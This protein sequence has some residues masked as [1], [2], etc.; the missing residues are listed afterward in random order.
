MSYE[1]LKA[2]RNNTKQ[3]LV[4]CLGGK[5]NRCSYANCLAALE[6]HHLDSNEKE[7]NISAWLSHPVKREIIVKEAKKCCLL[8]SNCHK[9]FHNNLWKMSDISLFIFDESFIPWFEKNKPVIC[10]HCQI[11][12]ERSFKNQ[13]FCSMSCASSHNQKTK[14][15][16]KETLEQLLW[17][18][19]STQIAKIYK[20]SDK[21]ICKWAKKYNLSKPP[22]GY[23]QVL[24]SAT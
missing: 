3:I 1:Q 22:R 10:E 18:V 21:S 8:C 13:R 17:M 6:F 12:T 11:E 23:W 2:W 5:C 15:P 4:D 16:D 14:I 24:K 19:P 20:V 7:G 9:E